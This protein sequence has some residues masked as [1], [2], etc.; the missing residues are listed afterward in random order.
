MEEQ[1]KPI[2]IEKNGV[3]YD[4]TGLYEVSNLGRVRSFHKGGR[5]L[6]IT[7]DKLGY[8]HARLYKNGENKLF[9]VHRLVATAFIFNPNKLPMVNHKDENPSN[10]QVENL[11]WCDAQYNTQYSSY[12]WKGKPKKD[13]WKQSIKG[14]N[15]PR[16]R[17][18]LCVETG[19]V[20]GCIKE[21]KQWLGKGDIRGCCKGRLK[22]AGGYHWMYVD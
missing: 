14:E 21:A 13:E 6:K 12:K 10:N 22:T 4:Y 15:N 3:V 19:R 1:W 20:F 16:A 11:E 2:I 17:K 7:T 9:Q 5:I 18:V 8:K